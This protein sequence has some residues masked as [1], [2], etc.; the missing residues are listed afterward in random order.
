MLDRLRAAL[1]KLRLSGLSDSLEVRLHEAQSH[2]LNHAEFLELLIQ[3]EFMVRSER[4]LNRRIKSACFRELKT[5]D[6][7][8]WSFNPSIKKKQVFDLAT[9]RFVRE[10]RD[11]LW[12]GPPGLGKSHLVQAIGITPSKPALWCCTARSSTW[13]ATSCMTMSWGKMTRS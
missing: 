12:L 10:A 3:D 1:K 9:G 11:V 13:S 5:L 4:L 7:F 6:Q 2:N 8:D